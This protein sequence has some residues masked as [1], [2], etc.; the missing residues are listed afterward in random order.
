MTGG[1]FVTDSITQLTNQYDTLNLTIAMCNIQTAV[2]GWTQNHQ[3]SLSCRDDSEDTLEAAHGEATFPSRVDGEI[4]RSDPDFGRF[5]PEFHNSYFHT[6]WKELKQDFGSISRMRLMM[7]RPKEC[8]S[9]HED[10]YR[11]LHIPITTNERSFFFINE[12]DN[13][14]LETDGIKLPS[15]AT[16]HLPA[17]GNAYVVDTTKY[18]SVYNGGRS[19]RIHLVC[20]IDD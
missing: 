19:D 1:G 8:L 10:F 18:H 16:Y 11:R 12:S 5:I 14:W 9:F 3:I 6:I 17:S 13:H 20:T 7:L 2:G 4:V 15:I